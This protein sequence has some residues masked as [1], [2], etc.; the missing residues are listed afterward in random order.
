MWLNRRYERYLSQVD[1]MV[2]RLNRHL[3]KARK[4]LDQLLREEDPSV[5]AVD[6]SKICFRRRD[7]EAVARAM[8]RELHSSLLLPIV[9][10][11]RLELGRGA[12]F[13]LGGKAE[14]TLVTRVLNLNEE[15]LRELYLYRV[16]VF[17][18]LGKLKSLLTIGFLPPTEKLS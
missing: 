17:E 16:Q 2:E 5:E 6:G 4:P 10:V 13:I 1:H 18:L 9:V 14:K 11:R 8:P 12:Y 15:E 3:P 7:I